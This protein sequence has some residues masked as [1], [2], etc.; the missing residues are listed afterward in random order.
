ME[1]TLKSFLSAHK[2][3]VLCLVMV[4]VCAS[5][6]FAEDTTFGVGGKVQVIVDFITSPWVKGIAVIALIIEA[7][8]LLTAGRQEPGMFKKFIPWIAGTVVFMAAGTITSK[9]VGTPSGT[10]NIA[11][12]TSGSG[13]QNATG[14]GN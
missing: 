6:L 4:M 5:G 1:K 14:S 7:I 2:E 11:T 8:G 3:L 10:S 9:F 12:S 13:N